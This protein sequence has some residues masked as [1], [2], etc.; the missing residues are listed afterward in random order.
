[1]KPTIEVPR[2]WIEE[3]MKFSNQFSTI[4]YDR[5]TKESVVQAME[6]GSLIGF[7]KSAEYFLKK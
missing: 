1:M 5:S 4:I 7:I 6:L 3:L 2:E